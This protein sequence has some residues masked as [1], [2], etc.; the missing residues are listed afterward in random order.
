MVKKKLVMLEEKM[1]GGKELEDT[2]YEE[3]GKLWL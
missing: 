3:R 2:G 1:R